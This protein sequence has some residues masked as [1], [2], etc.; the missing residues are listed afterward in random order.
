MGEG[1]DLLL[2][3]AEEL[4]ADHAHGVVEAWLADEHR[5][6]VLRHV[7]GDSGAHLI[8][9]AALDQRYD[10]RRPE[11]GDVFVRQAEVV[12]A[13]DLVLAHRDAADQLGQILGESGL[14]DQLLDLAELL[15][16]SERTCPMRQLAQAFDVGRE[17]GQ[18]VRGTLLG[19]D[20]FAGD[21][22]IT[23]DLG[24][25]AR[26]GRGEK[27]FGAADGFIAGIQEFGRAGHDPNCVDFRWPKS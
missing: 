21:L 23:R 9:D 12:G 4:L 14:Q 10:A 16:H 8:G 27:A 25:H 13:H 20:Q 11:R 6:R 3:K 19:I 26:L 17:P 15:L 18:P 1:R 24:R 7:I 22:S 5:A 2:C